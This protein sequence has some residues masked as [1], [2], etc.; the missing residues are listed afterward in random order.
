MHAWTLLGRKQA[1]NGS[2]NAPILTH[3]CQYELRLKT[4]P[5]TELNQI[6]LSSTHAPCGTS[7]SFMCE[8]GRPCD[9]NGIVCIDITEGISYCAQS[10]KSGSVRSAM[11]RMLQLAI[12][13]PPQIRG[14]LVALW[15]HVYQS[16]M[17]KGDNS[18]ATGCA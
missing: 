1:A 6:F 12:L 7:F 15:G 9:A 2:H 14:V 16:L 11:H 5:A 3:A 8:V 13:K 10:F 17:Y 18:S 4:R